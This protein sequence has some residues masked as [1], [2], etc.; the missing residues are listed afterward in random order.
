MIAMIAMIAAIT[1]RTTM[2]EPRERPRAL[3]ATD[4]KL[5]A[6]AVIAAVYVI[7]WYEVSA[8]SRPAERAPAAQRAVWL[9]Q[10]ASTERPSVAPPAGWQVASR[11]A[12]VAAPP[13][14]RAPASRP[15][16]LRTRSS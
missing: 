6:V 15:V 8:T 9:D 3:A 10:L 7:A 1:T 2:T 4:G 14:V 11:D 12:L 16:R 13:L 5:Y